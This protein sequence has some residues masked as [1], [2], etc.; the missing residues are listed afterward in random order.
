MSNL[1]RELIFGVLRR[2]YAIYPNGKARLDAPGGN[3][4]YAAAGLAVWQSQP[5]PGVVARVG[6]DYP[7]SWLDRFEREGLDIRGVRRLNEP[8]DLRHFVSYTDLHN[9]KIEDDPV[10]QFAAANLPF[11]RELFGYRPLVRAVDSRTTLLPTSLRAHDIPE[12]FRTA[13]A[14]HI[15]P[16]DYVSHSVL[17]AIL[18]QYGFTTIT[19]DPS[20][21]YMNPDSWHLL[22]ALVTGLT[23]F[24]P[25]EEEVRYLF[26]GRSENLR[27]MAEALAAWNCEIIVIKRGLAGQLI[28][29]GAAR[30]FWEIP[31]YPASALDPLG[32]GD[33]FC[34]GF[35]A[36]YRATFDPLEAALYGNISA[37]LAVEGYDPLYALGALPGLAAARRESLRNAVLQR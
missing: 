7:Q 20:P 33:A 10:Q 9:P 11:P 22:P 30:K 3:V 17:P 28:Y 27:E 25:S 18:R 26:K 15:C 4:L 5:A 6:S 29:D 2:Q 1:P 19:L 24:L 32:A 21:G 34:G 35:L 23:A 31:S 12:V 13:T 14:A 8:L 37:S 36:G 16:I